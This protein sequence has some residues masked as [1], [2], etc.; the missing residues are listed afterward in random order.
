MEVTLAEH[1]L[2]HPDWQVLT[3]LLL[4]RVRPTQLARRPGSRPRAVERRD[5]EQARSPRAGRPRPAAARSRRP[6]RRRRRAD[7]RQESRRGISAASIQGR[8]EAFFASALTP[9]EQKKLN[10]PPAQADA[11]VRGGRSR[12]EARRAVETSLAA[13]GGPQPGVAG[14]GAER[15]ERLGLALAFDAV[16]DVLGERRAV[17]EPVARAAAEQPPRRRARGAGAKRKCVSPVSSYWQTR[18]PTIGASASAGN[19][20]AA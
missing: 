14:A 11:R 8:K 2:T 7:G 1:G 6:A 10:A 17:L 19:R 13:R 18:E 9:T 15:V 20:F 5:D 16:R 4:S 12:A 3:T